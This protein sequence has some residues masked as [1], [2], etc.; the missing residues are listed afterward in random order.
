MSIS[1]KFYA[2]LLVFL[3]Y[4][5]VAAGQD[6]FVSDSL[7]AYVLREMKRWNIPGVA[8]TVVHNGKVLVA[9]GYGVRETGRPGAVDENTLFQIASCSKAFTATAVAMLAVDGRLSLDDKVTARMP[10][11]R[12]YDDFPTGEV[13]IRDLMCHRLGFRTFQGDFLQWDCNMS[14][15]EL[16]QNLRNIKPVYGFRSRY[17]YCN[18]GFLVAGEIIPLVT[19]TSW[20]DFL[21]Y[22]FFG[23]LAMRRTSTDRASIAGDG[24]AA[25]PYTMIDGKLIRVNYAD[26]E[27]LA[28]AASI[29]SCV[30]DMSHWL[31]AQLDSGRYG[32]VS[33]IP[34][35]A[36][37]ATRA[38]Q[39]V[40]REPS[41][42]TGRDRHFY[43]YG[44]GWFLFDV[45][46]VKVVSH[47]GG[48]NGFLSN[49]T[50]IP[51]ENFGF[52]ILTNTDA[53]GFYDALQE[54]LIDAVVGAP[55]VNRSREMHDRMVPWTAAQDSVRRALLDNSRGRKAALDLSEYAGSY[56]NEVYGLIEIRTDGRNLVMTFSHHPRLKGV[57]RPEGD[58]TFVC[59]YSDVTYGVKEF[60]FEV[61]DGRVEAVTVTVNDFIDYMPYRF[62][63][64][65]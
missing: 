18:A 33:V 43:T 48:A 12:L 29:N 54:Q 46:G 14:R 55:Y 53:N 35:A 3:S 24:N 52:T 34:Y 60:P 39:T 45:K 17:G 23:P 57:L 40:V 47:D 56:R 64:V 44:L 5:P 38:S 36:I 32:G 15:Q 13:T 11:F 30:A 41:D 21:K 7:D 62:T 10:A 42:P 2:L 16:I 65:R 61:I 28:P 27:A 63:R 1:M 6:R 49:T 9:R 8:V 31:L 37:R 50:L 59:E 51:Q 19:D 4:L 26:C 58:N 20:D 22:R 25:G